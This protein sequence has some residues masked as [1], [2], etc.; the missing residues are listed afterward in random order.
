[1]DATV[2]LMQSKTNINLIVIY[3]MSTK[4]AHTKLKRNYSILSFN[5]TF[6]EYKIELPLFHPLIF[7]F[8]FAF[9]SGQWDLGP[10]NHSLKIHLRPP[11]GCRRIN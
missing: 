2:Q 8:S 5:T 11:Y 10:Y 6:T 9:G 3:Q 1:M 4:I 7:F